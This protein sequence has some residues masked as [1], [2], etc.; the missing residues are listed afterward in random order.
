[1]SAN[2]WVGEKNFK[3]HIYIYIVLVTLICLLIMAE[4]N[5]IQMKI[6]ALSQHLERLMKQQQNEFHDRLNQLENKIPPLP[7]G[8]GGWQRNEGITEGVRLNVPPF[9]GRSDPEAYFDWE[10]K[11]EHA[12]SYNNYSKEQKVRLVAVE[13]F[14]YTLIWW[15]K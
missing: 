3:H 5:D 10:L 11:I 13:F 15:N 1:M 14:D 4:R 2:T 6:A 9:K 7:R 8:G 12:F